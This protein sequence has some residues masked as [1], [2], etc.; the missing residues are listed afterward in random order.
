[1][2]GATYNQA[3]VIIVL[4]LF[5]TGGAIYGV[6]KIEINDNPV[7]W[8]TESHPIRVADRTLN[9]RFAGTYMAYLTLSAGDDTG[10]ADLTALTREFPNSVQSIIAGKTDQDTSIQEYITILAA[11][12]DTAATDADWDIFDAAIQKLDAFKQSRE[13]FKHPDVLAYMEKLQAYL[14]NTGLVGKSNTL[15]DIIKTVHRELYEGATEAYR[16]PATSAA[17]AQT[18]LTYE[19][20]HRPQDLWHFVTPD[21]RRTNMW[22]QLKSGD[23]R[24]MRALVDAVDLFMVENPAPEAL[25][26]N[27]FGLTYINVVWQEKMVAGMLEAFAGSFVIVLLMMIFLFRSVAWGVLAMLPLSVTIAVIY[28]LIGFIGKDYDMPVAVLSALSLGL[29]VDYAIH[30]LARSRQLAEIHGA[31]SNTIKAVFG[32][33]ARAIT[34]NVVVVG[35]G[36]LP[37]LAAPLV[38]YQTVGVF[39]SAILVLAGGVTLLLLPSLITLLQKILFTSRGSTT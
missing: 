24:D 39:I 28:G 22:L 36:F 1:M 9:E 6:S 26:H 10:K 32:E 2:A 38:P 17:V 37:L 3:K 7:K 5:I 19:S 29:A 8:F 14:I 18:L 27:W 21:F 33:P 31:W 15:T 20:S 13:T 35:V 16:I 12:Q 11:A 25:Q 23:N 34:R 30:F 4:T